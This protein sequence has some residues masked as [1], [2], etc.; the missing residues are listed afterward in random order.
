MG[1]ADCQCGQGKWND[2]NLSAPHANIKKLTAKIARE[3]EFT[4]IDLKDAYLQMEVAEQYR[5]YLIIATHMGY[6]QFER[7]LFGVSASLLIFQ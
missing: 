7:L 4:V 6:F 1:N 2:Q 5:R 3:Q